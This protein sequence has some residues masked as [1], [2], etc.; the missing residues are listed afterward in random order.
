M[1]MLPPPVSLWALL[2][3]LALLLS[4]RGRV[5]VVAAAPPAVLV[6]LAAAAAAAAAVLLM[7]MVVMPHVLLASMMVVVVVLHLK[8]LL[9]VVVRRRGWHLVLHVERVPPALHVPL[10][11]PVHRLHGA[12]LGAGALRVALVVR[13]AAAA[14]RSVVAVGKVEAVTPAG[15]SGE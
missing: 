14:A 2:V 9:S 3:P 15:R 5:L 4:G 10:R 11:R 6:V 8:G 12:V 1:V 13:A 7:V